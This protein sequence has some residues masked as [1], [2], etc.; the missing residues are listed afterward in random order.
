M[1]DDETTRIDFSRA[2]TKDR[3]ILNAAPSRPMTH[4]R[5]MGASSGDASSGVAVQMKERSKALAV[6][7]VSNDEQANNQFI[8]DRCDVECKK[9]GGDIDIKFYRTCWNDC[10]GNP[11]DRRPQTCEEAK[12]SWADSP[13]YYNNI[14]CTDRT[15]RLLLIGQVKGFAVATAETVRTVWTDEDRVEYGQENGLCDYFDP[16][17]D[18]MPGLTFANVGITCDDY[19][20]GVNEVCE[21]DP[22]HDNFNVICAHAG[23]KY[24]AAGN[25]VYNSTG[26][27]D[28][29]TKVACDG[30]G[31]VF[32]N[33]GSCTT[34][35]YKHAI[36]EMTVNADGTTT[37]GQKVC[38]QAY[39]G[40]C[41]R[42]DI[43]CPKLLDATNMLEEI[44]YIDP[45]VRQRP[46]V[47]QSDYG[48]WFAWTNGHGRDDAQKNSGIELNMPFSTV[49]EPLTVEGPSVGGGA[50]FVMRCWER[51]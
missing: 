4:D 20:N 28:T 15:A 19:T 13:D 21:L 50:S 44:G 45:E 35:S 18:F 46:N 17:K 49:E 40:R 32:S 39:G 48:P 30:L 47:G 22:A 41:R 33:S 12:E 8:S 16:S 14:D 2:Y 6:L 26:I 5:A 36:Q 29:M 9:R 7:V 27:G 31:G 23:V 25:P 3:E 38:P 24:D 43:V 10:Y 51:T 11:Q 37:R 42:G 34:T 1:S